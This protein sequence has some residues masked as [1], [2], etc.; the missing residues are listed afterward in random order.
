MENKVAIIYARLSHEDINKDI[1]QSIENQ[2]SICKDYAASNNMI[3][4]DIYIDDG[5]SGTTFDRPNFIKMIEQV[6]NGNIKLILFKDLSRFG[7]DFIQTSYYLE[8]LFLENKVRYI[9]V[10]ENFDSYKNDDGIT[11]PIK[12]YLNGLYA[13][14]VRRKLK[15]YFK[16][17]EKEIVF[18]TTPMYGYIIKNRQWTLDENVKGTIKYIFREYIKTGCSHI[19][20]TKLKNNK[21]YCPGYYLNKILGI[22]SIKCPKNP[23]DWTD[24][25]IRIIINHIEY[26]GI[27]LNYKKIVFE[28]HHEPIITI[29]TFNKAQEVLKSKIKHPKLVDDTIRLKHMFFDERGK[30]LIYHQSKNKNGTFRAKRYKTKDL[31]VSIKAPEAHEILFKEVNHI[32]SILK[33]KKDLIIN[34]YNKKVLQKENNENFLNLKRLRKEKNETFKMIFENY[35]TGLILEKDYLEKIEFLKNGINQINKK[36]QKHEEEIKDSKAQVDKLIKFIEE[37]PN[38]DDSNQLDMIRALVSKVIVKNDE[39]LKFHIIYKFE[40]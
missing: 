31:K 22:T 27:A 40:I 9:S 34:K 6:K 30:V 36:I 10:S 12:N 23:Y 14:D 18:Q 21:V 38:L 32:Y 20:A 28:N 17:N 24:S 2:I 25:S 5:Y 7:R 3:I 8:D 26:T 29:K 11:L 15:Q 37:L 33:N 35:A 1:S 4:K 13:K 39:V 19:I 16:N